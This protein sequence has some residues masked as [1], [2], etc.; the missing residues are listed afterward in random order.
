MPVWHPQ[1]YHQLQNNSIFIH[2]AS[3]TLFLFLLWVPIIHY[4]IH[5]WSRCSWRP[6]AV[7]GTFS[8]WLSPLSTVPCFFKWNCVHCSPIDCLLHVLVNF[9]KFRYLSVCSPLWA[10]RS[11][12]ERCWTHNQDSTI[13][14]E[15]INERTGITTLTQPSTSPPR[16]FS[17][18]SL[19]GRTSW[20]Q[21]VPKVPSDV[22]HFPNT[23]ARSRIL[24][25]ME[26]GAYVSFQTERMSEIQRE[27]RS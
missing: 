9:Q 25:A 19:K 17:L 22:P 8:I 27:T 13:L 20:C 6:C 12:L 4:F 23:L 1:K 18:T 15:W 16:L 3:F 5:S 11:C 10:H 26:V 14:A 7:S 21:D 2:M 24:I